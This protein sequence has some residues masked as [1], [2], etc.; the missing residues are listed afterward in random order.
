MKPIQIILV[1]FGLIIFLTS[2]RVLNNKIFYRSIFLIGILTGIVFI[3]NQKILDSI[4]ST[5]GVGRGV[6]LI[7]YLIISTMIFV[8]IVFYKKQLK[9]DEI[10]T[11]LIRMNA[12][13]NSKKL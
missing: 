1:I 12:I 4:S 8:M 3:L 13:R 2:Y 9:Q 7:F 11:K 5:F 6:D 10:L